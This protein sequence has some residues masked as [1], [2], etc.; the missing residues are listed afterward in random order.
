MNL[1][2]VPHLKI[3]PATPG[4]LPAAP[5]HRRQTSSSRRP[6][7]CRSYWRPGGF[8][9]DGAAGSWGN[10]SRCAM[11]VFIGMEFIPRDFWGCLGIF[12]DVWGFWDLGIQ[13]L[14]GMDMDDFW[15]F[16]GKSEWDMA[17]CRIEWIKNG[18][19]MI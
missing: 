4:S 9:R 12:G 1:P 7:Q 19:R 15:E 18:L 6:A 14:N 16:C 17:F 5:W 11:G 13:L 2:P 8:R 10:G 3:F